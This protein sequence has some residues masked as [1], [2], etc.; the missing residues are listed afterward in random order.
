[1]L[2]GSF[3][4]LLEPSLWE[5]SVFFGFWMSSVVFQC[6]C[7]SRG[8][9]RWCWKMRTLRLESIFIGDVLDGIYLSIVS[10]VLVLTLSY[11]TWF[12]A[13]RDI[14]ELTLFLSGNSVFR[15]K[16]EKDNICWISWISSCFRCILCL[17][18]KYVMSSFI[19]FLCYCWIKVAQ[20]VLLLNLWFLVAFSLSVFHITILPW[21]VLLFENTYTI[22]KR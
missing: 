18:S 16:A 19:A 6:S 9:W 20:K 13:S 3:P 22:E 4:C 2:A 8:N 10:G 14:L 21:F 11:S 17:L 12:W 1:M 5:R 15:F 7:N